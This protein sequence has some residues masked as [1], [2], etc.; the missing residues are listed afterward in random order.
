VETNSAHIMKLRKCSR[1]EFVAAITDD[2]A[3]G[4]AKTFRAK[5]DMQ[6][7]WDEC[8]G[9]FNDEGE[10]MGAIITTL[11]RTEPKV[12]NLQLLHTF[13]KHRRKGVGKE[14]TLASYDD[15]AQRGAVYFRVSA[16]PPAVVFYE[17]LGFTFWGKQ[18]SGCSL[19]IFKING[20]LKDGLYNDKDPTINKALYSGRKGSLASSYDSQKGVD[21]NSFL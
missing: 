8:L 13:A 5:A 1:E 20:K 21:L 7:H 3:D 12:A 15:I 6:E 18:K 19:S 4:F 10:L 11:S 14:L 17:S 9:A 2:K 16:E